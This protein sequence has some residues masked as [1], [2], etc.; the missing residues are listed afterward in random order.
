[1]PVSLKCLRDYES[2]DDDNNNNHESGDHDN[3]GNGGS[4]I[5]NVDKYD[6]GF[7][8]CSLF[9]LQALLFWRWL[10]SVDKVL[11]TRIVMVAS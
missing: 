9:Q 11:L 2:S 8:D 7:G 1:M 10:N 3:G 4:V 6:S 5:W